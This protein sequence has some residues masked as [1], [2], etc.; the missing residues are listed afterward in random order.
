M[1]RERS[2]A[3]TMGTRGRCRMTIGEKARIA[4]S[5]RNYNDPRWQHLLFKMLF[6][7]Y[8]YDATNRNLNELAKQP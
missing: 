5:W 1:C 4:L 2:D 3:A 6:R 7:G 8:T